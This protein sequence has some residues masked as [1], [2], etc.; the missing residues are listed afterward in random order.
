VLQHHG[1]DL[2]LS[3]TP[4]EGSR[5][6]CVFPARRVRRPDQDGNIDAAPLSATG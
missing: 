4:G 6:V 3:S 2:E 5:F 1:G